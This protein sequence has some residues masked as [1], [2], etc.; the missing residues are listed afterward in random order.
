MEAFVT[1]ISKNSPIGNSFILRLRGEDQVLKS[2][3]N[4]IKSLTCQSKYYVI[5]CVYLPFIWILP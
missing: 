2:P 5:F 1:P 4:Q 3:F